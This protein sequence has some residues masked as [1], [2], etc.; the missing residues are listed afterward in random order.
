MGRHKKGQKVDGW[1]NLY[2][3][4]G[5]TST[6]AVGKV[7]RL[8][9]AQKAGHAGTLDPLAAG[10]LPIALGEATK[11]IPFTQ[12]RYKTYRFVVAWG[13]A[14][15]T[16][17]REGAVI[18]RSD[19][20]PA[21]AAIEAALP[22]YIGEITQTPPRFSAVKINGERAYDLARDGE[23]FEIKSRQVY[24]E[25]LRVIPSLSTLRPHPNPPPEGGG[26]FKNGAPSP[27]EG[28]EYGAMQ[29]TS[30][31]MICSKGTYVRSIARDMG[32]ML[33]T[34]GY[35][36]KLERVAVGPFTTDNAIFLETL[37]KMDHNTA[38]N[39]AL[40]PIETPLD[41]IPALTLKQQETTR[42]KNGNDVGFIARPDFI[43][44]S[45]AGIEDQGM[46][47]AV[48][49]NAPVA[50]VERDGPNIRP[51]RVFNL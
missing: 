40:L 15:S 14:R 28:I 8:F 39:S 25:S 23:E 18:A 30:F 20:R 36:S 47:L 4:E 32:E 24:V 34:C 12:D 3:P 27:E 42:L 19:I 48:F 2:K 21:R 37:D 38:Q 26:E 29:E 41:D 22:A 43:R 10:I 46:A 50:I 44:L 11:T 51:V 45:D 1:V 6:Q 49:Q 16:D 13:E 31:E 33:G 9:D 35:V 7:R 5:M 17:D